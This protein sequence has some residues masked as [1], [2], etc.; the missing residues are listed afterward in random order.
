MCQ[1]GGQLRKQHLPRSP[2]SRDHSLLSR[3]LSP[4]LPDLVAQQMAA[5]PASLC[6]IYK[7][8]C[9]P[10]QFDRLVSPCLPLN[11]GHV[12]IEFVFS[13][14]LDFSNLASLRPLGGWGP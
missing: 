13:S 5:S 12:L 1:I 3:G 11:M 6:R 4:T 14:P 8:W 7:P 9:Q 10:P 2:G